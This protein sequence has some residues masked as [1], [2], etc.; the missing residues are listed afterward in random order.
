MTDRLILGDF[1]N[2][3]LFDLHFHMDWISWQDSYIELVAEAPGRRRH[4]KF[5]SPR[6]LCIEQGFNGNLSGMAIMDISDRQ[7]DS[8]NL[9]VI[10]FEQDAGITFLAES[11]EIIGDT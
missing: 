3:K 10:N 11:M 5:S 2:M 1:S 7:W 4:L 9:E 6:N 8:T